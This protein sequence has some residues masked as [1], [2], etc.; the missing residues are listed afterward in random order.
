MLHIERFLRAI[1]PELNLKKCRK[2]PH[3]HAWN[4]ISAAAGFTNIITKTGTNLLHGSLFEF[5]RN[6]AFDAR[7]FFN[8]RSFA[9]PGRVPPFR[10]NEFGF[11]LGG[12]LTLPGIHQGRDRTFF[13]GEYQGFRQV[14][15]ATEVLSVPTPAE[16]Q[17]L[18]ATAF[19]GDRPDQIAVPV[20]ST[21]RNVPSDSVLAEVAL[22]TSGL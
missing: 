9:N 8:A 2:R 7:S 3:S 19:R 22:L 1:E 21:G 10:R 12:P 4:R 15:G 17:G 14:L 16:R 20:F 13:F 11:A 6:S 5:V 18:D